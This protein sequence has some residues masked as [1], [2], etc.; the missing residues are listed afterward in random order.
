MWLR[1]CFRVLT[2]FLITAKLLVLR[3]VNGIPVAVGF[4]TDTSD[5]KSSHR[6]TPTSTARLFDMFRINSGVHWRKITKHFTLTQVLNV[7]TE[8]LVLLFD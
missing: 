1:E 3:Y 5:L 6:R 8:V 4:D 7:S 2:T